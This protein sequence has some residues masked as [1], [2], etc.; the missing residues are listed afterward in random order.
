[1]QSRLLKK[2]HPTAR[3]SKMSGF[4]QIET[5][6]GQ[7]VVAHGMRLLPF[8]RNMTLRLPFLNLVLVWNRPISVLATRAGGQEQV[9]P[10]RDPTRQ[11]VWTLY[12]TI[13]A[14]TALAI[15]SNFFMRGKNE[16]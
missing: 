13:A 1:M 9:L 8:A 12:G 7:P 10:M 14:L 11:I 4:F 15:M 16:R 5:R 2:R 3:P 6:P